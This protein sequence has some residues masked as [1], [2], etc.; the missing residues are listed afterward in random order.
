MVKYTALTYSFPNL[1]QVCYSKSSSN[2]CFLTWIQTSQETGQ[3][4]RYSDLLKN[5]PQFVVIHIVKGFGIVNTAEVDVFLELSCFF[6]DPTDVG[7]L[8]SGSSAFSKPS[9]NIWKFL[10]HILLKPGLENFEHYFASMW[11]EDNYSNQHSLARPFFR[12]EMKTD[13]FQSCGHC[14]VFQI[15]L[16]I[17]CS[18]FTASSFRICN[19][20]TGCLSPPLVLF[21]VM[22]PKA[23]FTSR[24]RMF[25]SRWII[26]PSWLSESWRSFLC[27]SSVYSCYLF[28]IPSASV[29][30]IP[31]LSFIVPIFAWNFPLVSLIFLKTPLVFLILLFSSISLHWSQGRLSY[32]SLSLLFFRTL[33]SNGYIFPLPFASLLFSAICK[34]FSDN[35]FAFL[36]LSW[37]WSW[38]LP[39]VQCHECL[40]IVLQ[41]L[42]QI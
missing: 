42:Y 17:K 21:L 40:F 18:I 23:H 35:H 4:A 10:F 28:L 7:N 1:E 30:S 29:R 19:N 3:V 5:F 38:S 8:I 15:C 26:T 37:E 36:H 34:A 24:S 41:A 16:H 32:L 22:L 11:D 2:C 31:F 14:W 20:S 39:L 9:S 12:I 13:L 25:G 6:Y 33:H 27:R